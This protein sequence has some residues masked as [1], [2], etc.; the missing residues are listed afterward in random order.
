MHR[1]KCFLL[2]LLALWLPLQTAAAAA[3]PFCPHAMEAP[4]TQES[5]A[6][7]PCHQMTD[8][9]A[10]LS[11]DTA[12]DNCEMCHLT[13]AG[14]LLATAEAVPPLAASILVPR[15]KSVSASHITEP[16]QQPPRC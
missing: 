6:S 5:M 10:A 3:M 13:T 16:P 12:C 2:I 9:V 1:L 8:E 11:A 7:S 15:L 14:Y 4:V